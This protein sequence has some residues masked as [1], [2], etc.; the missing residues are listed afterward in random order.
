[1]NIQPDFLVPHG[2]ERVLSHIR[3]VGFVVVLE[4]GQ[5]VARPKRVHPRQMQR[6]LNHDVN[7]AFGRAEG[8]HRRTSFPL[9]FLHVWSVRV[10]GL[11]GADTL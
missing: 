1:M 3:V 11:F 2:R 9:K 7:E 8:L 10:G 4:P 5:P 6:L